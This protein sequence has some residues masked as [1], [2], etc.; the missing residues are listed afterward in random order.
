MKKAYIWDLDGTL[1]DSYDVIVESLHLA[2]QKFGIDLTRDEIH[3]FAIT[4]SSSA[5]IEKEA[6]ERGLDPKLLYDSY[7]HFSREKYGLIKTM[8]NAY[9]I[10]D[11]L[12]ERGARHYVFTHRGK[13]T[14]PVLRMLGMDHFF[15]DVLTSQSGFPRKPAPDAINY[16]L[17][18]HGFSKEDACYVGDR[19]LDM[20]SAKNAGIA[21]VL[22][23]P[24]GSRGA[25]SGA[26][27]Y[28]VHDLMDVLNLP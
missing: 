18:K 12:R 23:L 28:V 15:G 1:L 7:A 21:G 6:G 17:N 3:Q 25:P 2:F 27:S 20:E 14:L 9:M 4:F 16:L 26:E 8:P 10:L 22:Y 24:E 5:L 13:T 11:S 19:T